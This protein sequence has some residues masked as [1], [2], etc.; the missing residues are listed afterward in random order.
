MS[1][2]DIEKFFETELRVA[3][4][5][6]AEPIPNSNKL[7]KLT[8]DLGDE[9]RVLVAGIAR[10]YG[11]VQLLGRQ[12]VMVSNLQPVKLMGV[13]SQGMVL[14][15]SVDGT[16]VLLRPDAPVPNGTPVK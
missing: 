13:E 7:V 6:A 14:A 10:Q 1:V 9:T 11:S 8:V 5:T 3:T 16:P 12:I 2:I 15:A 4:V